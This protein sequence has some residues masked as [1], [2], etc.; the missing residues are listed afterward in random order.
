MWKK[1]V[2]VLEVMVL[3]FGYSDQASW[4]FCTC[5]PLSFHALSLS[6]EKRPKNYKLITGLL[7]LLD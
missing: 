4:H 7:A 6:Q 3:I 1:S 2:N 5:V